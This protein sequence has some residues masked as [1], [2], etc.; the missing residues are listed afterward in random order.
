[1]HL[2]VPKPKIMTS[3]DLIDERARLQKL[4][5][6]PDQSLIAPVMGMIKKR[7]MQVV[8]YLTNTNDGRAKADD[9]VQKQRAE[10]AEEQRLYEQKQRGIEQRQK[11]RAEESRR[12]TIKKVAAILK[13]A[14]EDPDVYDIIASYGFT[15][16]QNADEIA[17]DISWESVAPGTSRVAWYDL[18]ERVKELDAI[19]KRKADEAKLKDLA[20]TISGIYDRS[21]R[22][23]DPTLTKLMRPLQIN[24]FTDKQTVLVDLRWLGLVQ[25]DGEGRSLWE[26]VENRLDQLD[27]IEERV[28]QQ[29]EK[30]EQQ[31][32]SKPSSPVKRNSDFEP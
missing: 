29:R 12:S 14:L 30:A 2:V 10:E 20:S 8:D 21:R 28:R 7:L 26:V 32:Q 4:E 6:F 5:D 31:K 13:R 16:S 9:V 11:A 22:E 3:K 15:D 1:M 25:S 23:D 19:R 18:E 27:A 17:N 24:K